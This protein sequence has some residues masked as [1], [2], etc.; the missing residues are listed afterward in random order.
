[1]DKISP[2]IKGPR[3]IGT[4][5]KKNDLLR[6]NLNEFHPECVIAAFQ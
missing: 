6:Y 2:S 4:P 1:M 3:E 5:E